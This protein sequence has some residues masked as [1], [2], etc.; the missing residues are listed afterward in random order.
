MKTGLMIA[1]RMMSM[2]QSVMNDVSFLKTSPAIYT[3]ITV[4]IRK[5]DMLTASFNNPLSEQMFMHMKP[6]IPIMSAVLSDAMNI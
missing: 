6:A 3:H 4:M 2:G 5:T 1:C